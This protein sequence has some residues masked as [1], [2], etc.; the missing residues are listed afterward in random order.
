MARGERRGCP[1][2]GLLY[3][4]GQLRRADL[5]DILD[6]V[7]STRRDVLT[8]QLVEGVG[9]PRTDGGDQRF[10]RALRAGRLL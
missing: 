9:I 6:Q 8:R 2:T 3:L 4:A 10:R 1:V 5:G 7:A